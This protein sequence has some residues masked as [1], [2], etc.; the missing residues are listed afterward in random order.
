MQVGDHQLAGKAEASPPSRHA[1]SRL[2]P[3]TT[4]RLIVRGGARLA[5][6]HERRKRHHDHNHSR[7]RPSRPP[8]LPATAAE[9]SPNESS[10]S[11]SANCSNGIVLSHISPLCTETAHPSL[12]EP[13]D[14]AGVLRGNGHRAWHQDRRDAGRF[15]SSS[16]CSQ[17]LMELI[18]EL[19]HGFPSTSTL[20]TLSLAGLSRSI[21]PRMRN[22]WEAGSARRVA[23]ADQAFPHEG[24]ISHD[25]VCFG[26]RSRSPPRRRRSRSGSGRDSPRP[27]LDG[28][29]TTLPP[30]LSVRRLL[31]LNMA[32]LAE[33]CGFRT[34]LGKDEVQSL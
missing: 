16:I 32:K 10:T 4:G 22:F 12:P 5:I 21:A 13:G 23:S 17:A 19:R 1:L 3:L 26:R 6:Q 25:I 33:S 14:K 30:P 24:G 2:E 15:Q 28:H 29:R 34:E 8:V 27:G 18:A 9:V 7:P 11:W 31:M 20:T